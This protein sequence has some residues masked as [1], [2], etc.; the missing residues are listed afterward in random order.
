MPTKNVFTMTKTSIIKELRE[1]HEMIAY[2]QKEATRLIES[3]GEGVST[4]SQIKKE[5]LSKEF[6]AMLTRNMN[7]HKTHKK[8]HA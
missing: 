3:L 6:K 2:H 1:H 7:K 5:V 4:S 8:G